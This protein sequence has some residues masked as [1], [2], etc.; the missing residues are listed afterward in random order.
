[1]ARS[2]GASPKRQSTKAYGPDFLYDF[3]PSS[4]FHED[5]DL[6]EKGDTLQRVQSAKQSKTSKSKPATV[7]AASPP[8]I[9]PE[10]SASFLTYDQQLQLIQLQKEKLELEL[11]VLSLSHRECPQEHTLEGFTKEVN[12][13][14]AQRRVKRSIDWPHDFVPSIQGEYDKVNLSKFVSGFLIMIKA[15]DAKLKEA[16]LAHLE[17]LMTKAISY[18]WSSVRAFHKFVASK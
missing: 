1:M 6:E 13:P 5:F 8:P 7:P 16:F 2:A 11:K 12:E 15:Y 18:S 3:P 4:L 14:A 17:L 10:D 9:S